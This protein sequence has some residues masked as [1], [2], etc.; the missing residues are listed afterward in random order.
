M[1]KNGASGGRPI[2]STMKKLKFSGR[3]EAVL[4]AIDFSFGS[5]G[6]EIEERT[7]M[8]AGDLTDILN[9]LIEGGFVE[10]LPPVDQ[11]SEQAFRGSHFEIN[12]SYAFEIKTALLR[13]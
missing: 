4:R 12:P 8:D 3:E 13:T 2:V 1:L 5:D 11:V 6:S 9:G 10:L 7:S